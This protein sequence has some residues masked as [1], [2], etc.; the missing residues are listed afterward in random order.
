MTDTSSYPINWRSFLSPKYWP[1]WLGFLL[2]WLLSRLPYDIQLGIGRQIGSLVWYLLP[3]RRRVTLTNLAIGFPDMSAA[4][5]TQLA[6][7]VYAHVGMSIAEGASLWFRPAHFFDKRFEIVGAEN[8]QTA[9]S[10]K[11]GVI[12][13]QAHFSLLEMNAAILGPLF[14]VS[15]VFDP[16]KNELFAAFLANRRSRYLQSLID[17]RQMRQMIRKLKTNEVVWYSPD[18]SVSR[19]HGGIETEFF[20]QPVLTTA[21]T[22]RIASMTGAAVLPLMPTRHGNT[23]RY[24]LTIGKPIRLTSD[25]DKGATQQVNDI[26]EA[27]VRSQP[28]QYFWMHKRFKPPSQSQTNPYQR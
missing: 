28:E 1:T 20:G 10:S 16:P 19:S 9:L 17:N 7:K 2:L 22:R 6:R 5:R 4:A 14:P 8:L 18:Q 27:Q 23:G 25:D 11:R 24:T 13:L 26:F 3:S 15:A 12:L 21:G